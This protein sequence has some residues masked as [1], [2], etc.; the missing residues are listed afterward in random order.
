[1]NNAIK[2]VKTL[3]SR[4]VGKLE[5]VTNRRPFVCCLTL[6]AAMNLL[7]YL[8]H[9]RSLTGALSNVFDGFGFFLFNSLILISFFSLSLFFARRIFA[10][11]LVFLFW[12]AMGVTDCVL[13][14]M[15]NA[16]LEGIDFYILRTGF[17]IIFIYMSIP[18]I[19][20]WAFLI[21]LSLSLIVLLFIKLPKT[22]PGYT[23]AL[24]IFLCC[25]LVLSL[26]GVIATRDDEAPDADVCGFPYFFLRS[27]FD[28][29]INRPEDYSEE[30]IRNFLADLAKSETPPPQSTPNIIFVQLESFFDVTRMKRVSFSEDPI[31][32]FRHLAKEYPSGTLEV[33][34]IGSGTAN[35][36]F[37]V[38]S[39]LDL[40]FFGTGE[41]P[42]ESVLSDK[43]CET[44]AFLL[45]DIG[46]TTHGIHNHTATFYD[47]FAVYANLGF[48]TFTAAEH[49]EGVE[50][51]AIGWEK[52]AVL[53]DYVIKALQSSEGKDFVFTVSV[54]AHGKYPDIPMCDEGGITVFGIEG[55]ER[56]NAFEFYANELR[57]TDR[58]IG[59]LWDALNSF[60]E[61]FVL[62]LYGD[63]RPALELTEEKLYGGGLYKTDY[64]DTSK[65]KS[66]NKICSTIRILLIS[67]IKTAK[68]NK[69]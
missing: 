39:G 21:L 55:E 18:E 24:L 4:I 31:P 8:L 48:D 65:Y 16:P 44:A 45:K 5:S 9:A 13:M 28:R 54:Q 58:F 43:C 53:T 36:Q 46:Y 57:A 33:E 64:I 67:S 6:G 26:V 22:R 51:N 30:N 38:L 37:E 62:V 50:Y 25:L 19:V 20:L 14:S 63:H 15:R 3:F 40:S 10:L 7:I 49:M 52:D 2:K 12:L 11:F 34:S 17:N 35:T 29:G 32:N 66:I 41:Y 42:Y 56:K 59:E 61:D 27:I 47:R 60:G 23:R 1:M 69:K 68:N